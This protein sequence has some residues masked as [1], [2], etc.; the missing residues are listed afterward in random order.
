M[1]I[2]LPAFAGT[3]YEADTQR[4]LAQVE[5][6]LEHKGRL[7]PRPPKA[8]V[9][10]HSSYQYS[11]QT[12]ALAYQQ[13]DTVYDTIRRV[14]LLGPSHKTP[15]DTLALPIEDA[16]QTPLGT[17]NVDKTAI[18]QFCEHPMFEKNAEAHRKEHSLEV[19]LPF[20]QVALDDFQIVPIVVGNQD[21][22]K[23]KETLLELWGDNETL[24]IISTGLS[25]HKPYEKVVEENQRSSERVRLYDSTFQYEQACG[26]NVLNA[27][28]LLAKEKQLDS[29]CLGMST[30]ADT[31][32]KKDRVRGFGAFAFY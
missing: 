8:L 28:L 13:L 27:F 31:T 16:F 18:K 10:P 24:F 22:P 5:A 14:V 2:R 17:V 9:V 21:S 23:I 11:A 3:L 7:I 4:L 6:W 30:S 29:K 19:Q 1:N 32:G 25:R 20:L 12:A 15:L 26:Y